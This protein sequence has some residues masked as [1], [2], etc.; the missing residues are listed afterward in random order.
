[1][2]D[3]VINIPRLGKRDWNNLIANII[4][5]AFIGGFF[6]GLALIAWAFFAPTHQTR[7]VTFSINGTIQA[8]TYSD[9]VYKIRINNSYVWLNLYNINTDESRTTFDLLA[10]GDCA[11]LTKT[12]I[13]TT[14][15]LV[16]TH[17]SDLWD[18]KNC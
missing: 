17:S 9:H 12:R 10:V 2:D 5:Y 13:N 15:D 11:I 18:I 6:I 3:I 1:M 8:K 14:Y 7:E 4:A 16:Y